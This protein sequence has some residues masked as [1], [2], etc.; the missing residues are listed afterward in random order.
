MMLYYS[1]T[2]SCFES[3]CGCLGGICCTVHCKFSCPWRRRIRNCVADCTL[4]S[5][6]CV[7]VVVSTMGNVAL[8]VDVVMS[9]L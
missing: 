1:G 2:T 8:M 9:I 3:G 6:D 5:N 7:V 4:V